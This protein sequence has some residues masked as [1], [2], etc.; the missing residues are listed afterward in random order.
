MT[1]TIVPD[2][3]ERSIVLPA[4]R[5]RVWQAV[6][7]PE[8]LSQWMMGMVRDIDFRVGGEMRFSW[9]NEPSPYT[10]TIEAIE[11][12]HRFAYRWFAYGVGHPHELFPAQPLTLVE[13]ILDEVAEG[14]RLTVVE[15][16]FAAMPAIYPAAENYQDNTEGWTMLLNQLLAYLQPAA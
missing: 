4:S 14:T 6:T 13:F 3:I 10:G 15:S 5:E 8:Q 11:E 7:Q 12:P 16:G 2:R 1:T 9:E